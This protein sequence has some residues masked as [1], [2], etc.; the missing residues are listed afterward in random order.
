M[1]I[2]AL[3]PAANTI[4]VTIFVLGCLITLTK[5]SCP[6][7]YVIEPLVVYCHNILCFA[8]HEQV[9]HS[10]ESLDYKEDKVEGDHK[11]DREF[12]FHELAQKSKLEQEGFPNQEEE[13]ENE[14]EV[15]DDLKSIKS[16]LFTFS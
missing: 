2:P 12:S 6:E 3:S 10:Q 15:H 13:P 16:Y 4:I 5:V 11:Q 14:A 8:R 1:Y 9:I 7:E